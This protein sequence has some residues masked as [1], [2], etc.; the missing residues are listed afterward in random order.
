MP[1]RGE[2][3]Q[4][5]PPN[6]HVNPFLKACVDTAWDGGLHGR[7]QAGSSMRSLL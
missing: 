5:F 3:P 7:R 1:R 6:R 2:A 4:Q